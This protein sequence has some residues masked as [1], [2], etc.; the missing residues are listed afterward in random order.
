MQPLYQKKGGIIKGQSGFNTWLTNAKKLTED[1]K[2]LDMNPQVGNNSK[3]IKTSQSDMPG[4]SMNFDLN[5][6][7]GVQ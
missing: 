5:D 4:Q 6:N 2:N 3:S 1:I 7:N